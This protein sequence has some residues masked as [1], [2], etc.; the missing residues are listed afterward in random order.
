MQWLLLQASPQVAQRLLA[1]TLQQQQPSHVLVKLPVVGLQ[2]PGVQVLQQ[3][4]VDVA[5]LIPGSRAAVL[6]QR[7]SLTTALTTLTFTSICT[8]LKNS[9]PW[10]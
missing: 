7:S 4:P 8:V 6:R 1:A 5:L 2:G 3:G 10:S 9:L